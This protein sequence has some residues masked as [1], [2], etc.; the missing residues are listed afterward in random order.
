ML[1]IPRLRHILLALSLL[2]GAACCLEANDWDIVVAGS[3]PEAIAAAVS[4]AAGGA[5]TLLITGHDRLGGLFVLGE[6][7]VLD[8]RTQPVNLQKGLFERWWNL[9]GR[10]HSFDVR[11][12]QRAFERL[13]DEA[14]GPVRTGADELVP[15]KEGRQVV[16]VRSGDDVFHAGQVIDGPADLDFG[17]LAGARKQ[18]GYEQLVPEASLRG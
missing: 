14:G 9:V 1:L 17:A 11:R 6:L 2:L 5:S 10:G 7:N 16:G 12:A 15:V 18:A 13:L 4:A 3:E 8:L